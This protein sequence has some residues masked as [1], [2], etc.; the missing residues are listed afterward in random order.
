[1]GSPQPIRGPRLTSGTYSPGTQDTQDV[2]LLHKDWMKRSSHHGSAI[3]NPTGIHEGA[4]L[5][6]GLAQWVKELALP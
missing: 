6:P 1:M 5:I 3:S 4:G 2:K